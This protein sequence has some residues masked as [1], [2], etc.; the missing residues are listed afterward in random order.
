[1]IVKNICVRFEV[2]VPPYHSESGK[3]YD[4]RRNRPP[5]VHKKCLDIDGFDG[6]SG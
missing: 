1:M 2:W 4:H 3:D 6:P 5:N